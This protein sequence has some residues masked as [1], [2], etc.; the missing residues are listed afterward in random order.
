MANFTKSY[1]ANVGLNHV[2]AYQ[3]SGR[4]WAS[5]S[6]NCKDDA[7]I[8]PELEFPTVTRWIY[9]TNHGADA[10]RV[11]FSEAGVR[12]DNYFRVA[13]VV[14]G[15][16]SAP[17]SVR[18]EVKV[19][20]LYLSGSTSVDVVAGLTTIPEHRTSGSTGPSWS[21]SAGVG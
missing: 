9:V 18:L 7:I 3:A 12:G 20:K 11:G 19:S 21:G 4:P 17:Q 10:V 8:L 1:K 13:G 5:G 6:I 2:P 16:N 14:A 15:G